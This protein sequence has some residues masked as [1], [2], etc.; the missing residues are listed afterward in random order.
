MATYLTNV[1]FYLS[2][3]ANPPV[4]VNVQAHPV[5]QT[6]VQLR[7]LLENLEVWVE[8]K[9]DSDDDESSEDDSDDD[10]AAQRRRRK[11][12][13][14]EQRRLR[15]GM[16]DLKADIESLISGKG[17]AFVDTDEKEEEEEEGEAE[18]EEV[19]EAVEAPKKRIKKTK[20]GLEV[21]GIS[22]RKPAKEYEIPEE[23]Y[24][25]VGKDKKLKSAKAKAARQIANDFGEANEI[26][27]M[28]IDDKLAR[29]RSLKFHVT[30]VDQVSRLVKPSNY[31]WLGR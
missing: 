9:V 7:E 3:R 16:P 30:K 14:K 1:A 27:D 26:D 19:Y 22:R 18:I 17:A 8:G 23:A 2:L 15:R 31:L 25:P 10:A 6:L 5:V 4:G 29:K 12:R 13:R 11:R 28:D 24:V 21:N 20:I